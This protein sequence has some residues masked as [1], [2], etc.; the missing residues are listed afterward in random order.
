MSEPDRGMVA[1][2]RLEQ[3]LQIAHRIQEEG[4]LLRQPVDFY[5]TPH[6]G[7]MC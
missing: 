6:R 5:R 1:K 2:A 7:V 3:A 4:K